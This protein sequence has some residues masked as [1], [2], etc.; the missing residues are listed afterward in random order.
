MSFNIEEFRNE[1]IILNGARPSKFR[2]E[3]FNLPFTSQ[4]M[5][6]LSFFVQA[7]SLP[8]W[9]IGEVPVAYKGRLVNFSGDRTF[10]PW[11][12]EV[13]NDED[14]L[15]RS[16]FEKWQNQIN[17]LISNRMDPAAYPLGYKASAIVTQEGQAGGDLRAYRFEGLWPSTIDPIVLNFGALNQ[18]EMFGVTFT[19]DYYEPVDQSS[20]VDTY[21]PVLPD[22]AGFSGN[23]SGS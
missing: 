16:I 10:Q 8:G 2:V 13:M 4:N 1:G 23:I 15:A 20:S 21:S 12:V 18:I 5:R 14:F 9:T 22:D 17:A 11:Q 6:R 19:Y 3:L 7:A